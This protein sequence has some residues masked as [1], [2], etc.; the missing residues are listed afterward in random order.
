MTLSPT[1]IEEPSHNPAYQKGPPEAEYC[2]NVR[3]FTGGV[4]ITGTAKYNQRVV[5]GDMSAG[6]LGSADPADADHP[7]SVNPI[8][9]AEIRVTDASGNEVQCAETKVDGTFSFD[10]PVSSDTYTVSIDSRSNNSYLVASV[11]N[12]PEFN[13]YYAITTTVVPDVSKSVGTLTATADGDVMAGPFNILDQ[14]LNANDYLRS[15]VGSCGS[16]FSGCTSFTVAPKVSAYWQKGFNPNSYFGGSSGLSFYLPGYYRLFILGGLNGDTDHSDTD[17]FDNSVIIHEYGHFLED[18][19]FKSD[20]PGGSHN[21]NKV[22]DG[23]LAWSEGW[24]DFIQA[25]VRNDAHYID[26]IGNVDGLTELA[27]YVDLET[28]SVGSDYPTS[29]GEGNFREFAVTRLLWDAIDNTST[30]TAFSNTDNVSGKFNEI[31][32]SLTKSQYGYRDPHYAFRNVGYLHLSQE[33]LQANQSASD[34]SAIR[35]MNRHIGDTSRFAQ[36]VEPGTCS[37]YSITPTYV[38]S[39]TGSLAT[40]DPFY[41]N[42]FYYLRVKDPSDSSD[43]GLSPGTYTIQLN[44]QDSDGIGTEADLD[45]YL[46]NNS[47]RFGNSSDMISYSRAEPDYNASSGQSESITVTLAAGNYLIDV[48]VYTGGS[49]GGAAGFTLKLN[50][51]STLCPT[52]LAP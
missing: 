15:Q 32:A 47:A 3:T 31:W 49:I 12:S 39:D 9:Y 33:W 44:Y 51:G 43:I 52:N 48:N 42:R 45:L 24:G 17:T 2:S 40:S 37:S 4:T 13:Q 18:S 19:M 5:F 8:R 36:Y 46:Y 22:L 11:L 1:T 38:S 28:A 16:T 6:G 27:F 34:W 41:N 26:T 35:A 10:L 20:S 14:L 25:A 50:D 23:R 7:A 30:E 29:S 21:G